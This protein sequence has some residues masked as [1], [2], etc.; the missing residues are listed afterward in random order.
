MKI[1][2]TPAWEFGCYEL[3]KTVSN[4]AVLAAVLA[5]LVAYQNTDLNGWQSAL[6]G[7]GVLVVRG[8]QLWAANN[9]DKKI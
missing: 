2:G 6:V 9:Q 5:N 7:L 3:R 4:G 8:L 1:V